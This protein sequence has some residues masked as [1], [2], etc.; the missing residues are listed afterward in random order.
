MATAS[1]GQTES[2]RVDGLGQGTKYYFAIK[3]RDESGRYSNLSNN[4][5]ATTLLDVPYLSQGGQPWE[6]PEQWAFDYYLNGNN[7]MKD[8]GCSLTSLAMIINYYAVYHPD[9]NMR[10]K[11]NGKIA[12]EFE[13]GILDPHTL[14]KYIVEKGGKYYNAETHDFDF[15]IIDQITD[16]AVV[17]WGPSPCSMDVLLNVDLAVKRSNILRVKDSTHSVVLIGYRD[18]S[19]FIINNPGRIGSKTLDRYGYTYQSI[20]EFR[21]WNGSEAPHYITFKGFT[22]W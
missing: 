18:S 17:Y 13:G 6:N 21:E 12:T 4:T 1:A 8:K 16:G 15:Q 10:D 14:N 22:K 11:I 3:A 9:K 5:T 19:G 2:Y 7:Y 20:R